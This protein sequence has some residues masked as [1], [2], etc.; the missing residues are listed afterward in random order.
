MLDSYFFQR[1]LGPQYQR[2][3]WSVTGLPVRRSNVVPS[4]NL[5]G[6]RIHPSV[7]RGYGANKFQRCQSPT[8]RTVLAIGS[9]IGDAI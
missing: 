8:K 6:T 9:G 1:T 2:C 4:S 7:V 3:I 5:P